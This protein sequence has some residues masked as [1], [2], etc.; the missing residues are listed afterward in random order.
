MEGKKK[1]LVVVRVRGL[2][3]ISQ[4]IKDTLRMLR[5]TRNCHATLID[6]RPVYLG[7]LHKAQNYVTW[8]EISKE[9]VAFLLKKRGRLIGD[10]KLTDEYAQEI[11]YK[12]LDDLAE[13]VYKLEVEYGRLPKVKAV[14]RLH[15]PKKGYKGKVKRSY[16]AGGVTGYRGEAINDLLKRMM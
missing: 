10:K 15:P 3:D 4:E 13:S 9:N 16:A 14:F 11:G 5:L 1:C 6:N 12:S 7:M 8:G 2:S